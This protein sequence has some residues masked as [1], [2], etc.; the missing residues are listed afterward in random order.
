MRII[1]PALLKIIIAIIFTATAIAMAVAA[2]WD[3]S[4]TVIDRALMVSLSVGICAGAILIPALS[5][6]KLAFLLSGCCM[7]GSFYSH[8]TYFTNASIRAGEDRAKNALQ[9]VGSIKQINAV[10]NALSEINA[11][12]VSIVAAELA[13]THAWR[14]RSALVAELSE[15]K[16]SASL[17]DELV[18]LT[19]QAA[20]AEITATID[21]V[22]ARLAVVIGSNEASITLVVGIYFAVLI[23]LI[24]AMLWWEILRYRGITTI[25]NPPAVEHDIV[26]ELREAVTSG[27]CKPTVSAIRVYLGCSQAKAMDFRRALLTV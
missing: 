20:E 13:T 4:G 18:K 9:V 24:S 16:R 7:L 8:I 2:A 11:R 15:A 26:T 21:P 23:E 14:Q 17:Q 10:N 3:R 19:R 25:G 1:N 12:P 6:Q 22:T 5:K 27:V